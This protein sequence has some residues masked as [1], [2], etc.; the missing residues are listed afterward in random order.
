M[1][2]IRLQRFEMAAPRLNAGHVELAGNILAEL[3]QRD[4]LSAVP[5]SRLR[6]ETI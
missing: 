3:R 6:G 4:A 5:L 2:V 1:Y